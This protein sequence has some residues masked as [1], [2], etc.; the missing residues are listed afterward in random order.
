MTDH[1]ADVARRLLGGA[2]LVR[3]PGGFWTVEGCEEAK[4][5]VP[6]WNTTI[7]TVRAMEK[8]GWLNRDKQTQEWRDPRR[9]TAGGRATL[10]QHAKA[11]GPK[12]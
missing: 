6:T 9:L 12:T 4:P 11:S 10:E 8:R 5:G 1:Q 3:W 2:F 7:G